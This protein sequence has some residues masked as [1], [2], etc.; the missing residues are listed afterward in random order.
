L[1][2]RN[3]F[4]RP[5]NPTVLFDFAYMYVHWPCHVETPGVAR[6]VRSKVFLVRDY[7]TYE[8]TLSI[9]MLSCLVA[10]L[11]ITA[12]CQGPLRSAPLPGSATSFSL[13]ESAPLIRSGVTSPGPY[14][15]ISRNCRY[16]P[17]QSAFCTTWVSLSAIPLGL[18]PFD[19]KLSASA[20]F[21]VAAARPE[22]RYILGIHAA[23]ILSFETCIHDLRGFTV[24]LFIGVPKTILKI[25]PVPSRHHRVTIWHGSSK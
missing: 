20:I 16:S 2:D 25:G 4:M 1:S 14:P 7:W 13:R 22:V 9:P 11:R 3:S 19:K 12:P 17:G 23:E 10:C 18:F 15:K 8:L 5:P 21:P 6:A 24:W